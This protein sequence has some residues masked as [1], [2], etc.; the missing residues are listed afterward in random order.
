MSSQ[1]SSGRCRNMRSRR[2]KLAPTKGG[3]SL[4]RTVHAFISI[5]KP[6]FRAARR[7]GVATVWRTASPGGHVRSA[8]TRGGGCG[9]AGSAEVDGRLGSRGG[10]PYRRR[11]AHGK[12]RRHP[13]GHRRQFI[14]CPRWLGGR[15]YQYIGWRH[16]LVRTGHDCS[17]LTWRVGIWGSGGSRPSG[18]LFCSETEMLHGTPASVP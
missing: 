5:W 15:C 10:H 18:P 12:Y 16:C 1:R 4:N 6:C 3:M 8:L 2:K 17:A 7:P 13:G 9:Y 11:C 14:G